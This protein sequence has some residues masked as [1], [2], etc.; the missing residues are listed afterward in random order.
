MSLKI[1]KPRNSHHSAASKLP[2]LHQI[3]VCHRALSIHLL[4]NKSDS[5]VCL[6]TCI[7]LSSVLV[8]LSAKLIDLFKSPS[9]IEG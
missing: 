7:M 8:M 1:Y 5:L 3:K 9:E 6:T 4:S 2:L